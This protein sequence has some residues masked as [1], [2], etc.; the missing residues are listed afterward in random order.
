M[1]ADISGTISTDIVLVGAE[2]TTLGSDTLQLLLRWGVG[3]SNLHAHLLLANSHAVVLADDFL[4]L[5]T[6]LEAAEALAKDG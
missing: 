3:I 6:R 2:L 4:A 1:D 5:V